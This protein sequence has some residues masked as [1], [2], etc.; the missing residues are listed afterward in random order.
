MTAKN[1]I[2]DENISTSKKLKGFISY[3]QEINKLSGNTKGKITELINL[4]DAGLISTKELQEKITEIMQ[5]VS[6]KVSL[7]ASLSHDEEINLKLA[8]VFG[9]Q[10]KIIKKMIEQDR[11]DE[12][13]IKQGQGDKKRVKKYSP[14]RLAIKPDTKG[15][16]QPLYSPQKVP[17]VKVA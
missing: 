9:T 15:Y 10:E 17:Y 5:E 4:S 12:N 1:N 7:F 14:D 8:R 6:S 2:L 13:K 16:H 11:E 3:S